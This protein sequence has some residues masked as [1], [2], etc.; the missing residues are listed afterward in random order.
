MPMATGPNFPM[1]HGRMTH[2]FVGTF[3]DRGSVPIERPAGP[4]DLAA[5]PRALA[6]S[7]RTFQ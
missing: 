2:S 4:A 6:L 3:G 7:R 1:R 5:W